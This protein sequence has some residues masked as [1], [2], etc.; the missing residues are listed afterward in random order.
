MPMYFQKTENALKRAKEFIEV[1]KKESGLECLNDVIH[2]KKHRQ[3]WTTTH[4][5]IMKLFVELC[6]DLQRSAFAK[7]GLYQYR[8][9]CREVSLHSFEVVVKHFLKLASDRADAAREESEQAVL[10]EVEDLDLIMTPENLL[11]STV[12]GEG[13]KER[14][15]RVLLA[16]W[17]KFL[18][19]S[20]RNMLELLKNN[21]TIERVYADVAKDAFKFCLKY[22]R[23]TEFRKLCEILKNHLSQAQK[24]QSQSH[25]L[26][27][28]NPETIQYLVDVRFEQL[29]CSI[30]IDLWQEAFKAIEEIHNLLELSGK[31]PKPGLLDNYYSRQAKVYWM[32]NNRL[33][34]AA[35]LHKLFVLWK[36]QKKCVSQEELQRIASRVLL[37]TLCVPIEPTP[38][39]VDRFLEVDQNNR[40]KA[41]RL[42][43]LL[44][45]TSLPTRA[46]LL[47][48]VGRHSIL[49]H[50]PPELQLLYTSLEVEFNPLQ[51]CR[52]V[53]PVLDGLAEDETLSQY[54]ESTREVLLVR[55]IKEVSQVYET[56]KLD[57]LANLVPFTTS[58]HLETVVIETAHSNGIQV[59][60]DH[61]TN[62]L[63]FGSDMSFS[64]KSETPEGPYVQP[65]P[66]EALC[67]Q[68][69]MFSAAL[70]QAVQI[71]TI[72]E[73]EREQA[74]TMRELS[75][76]YLDHARVE[77]RNVLARKQLIEA[78]KE[79]IESQSRAKEHKENEERRQKEEQ[80]R[81]TELERLER[82][83]EERAES[84]KKKEFAERKRIEREQRIESLKK[85][86]IGIR[87][88][89]TVTQE[90]DN[91]A[92]CI[93]LPVFPVLL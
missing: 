59:H 2:S 26:R 15:D 65:M 36:E 5:L 84:K 13:V 85:T 88:L 74:E 81:K 4:E 33:F 10:H 17:V 86:P 80:E 39:D 54:V 48:D 9:I 55:L 63:R 34:H 76:S 58:T 79:Y 50:T 38:S 45:M 43:A 42:A 1:D 68:L 89:E 47:R 93:L 75:Q 25:S 35:A 27:F 77:H 40:D 91:S 70:Q 19:E 18:W 44:R 52:K 41:R 31:A 22:Q 24:Y 49:Q 83:A 90:V 6:V 28:D 53:S 7:D 14:S 62:C 32:A 37:A 71:I 12:S 72:K 3:T 82:E 73:S 23:R 87:A 69:Q 66:S 61:Q 29:E 16:P 78:R 57:W 21:N 30:S 92:P 11:L 56:V 60:I 20:Y 46:S 64:Y 51:L 67:C 8:N